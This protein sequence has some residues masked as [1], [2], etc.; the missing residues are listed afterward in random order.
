MHEFDFGAASSLRTASNVATAAAW[1][2]GSSDPE[3]DV[4]AVAATRI[5]SANRGLAFADLWG[6][7]GWIG[8]SAQALLVGSR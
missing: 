5:G 8:R 7:N 3:S 2:I 4:E 1:Y 6:D